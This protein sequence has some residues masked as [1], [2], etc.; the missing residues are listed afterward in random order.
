ML[1]KRDD[2]VCVGHL[3]TSQVV[4]LLGALGVQRVSP[5]RS[6]CHTYTATPAER[7]YLRRRGH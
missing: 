4:L 2:A 3:H 7:G 6:Q 5:S 1:V